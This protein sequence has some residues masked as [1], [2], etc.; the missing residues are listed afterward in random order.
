MAGLDHNDGT[1]RKWQEI[2]PFNT[3]TASTFIEQSRR[4]EQTFCF[5]K[6]AGF[7]QVILYPPKIILS[8]KV[9]N[10]KML[11][12]VVIVVID[13]ISRRHFYR[14]M[15]KSIDALREIDSDDSVQAAVFDFELFQSISMHTF[16]NLRPLF[17]GVTS[18]E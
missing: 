1:V 13:S 3:D 8:D 6:C 2:V 16:D 9:V 7:S 15:R 11:P 10:R 4:L 18:G 14:M 5:I 12:N 17:S